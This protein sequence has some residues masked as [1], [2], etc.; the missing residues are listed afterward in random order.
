MTQAGT[1]TKRKKA[2]GAT[3]TSA[4]LAAEELRLLDAYWRALN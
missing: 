2:D 3:A 1:D 4:P